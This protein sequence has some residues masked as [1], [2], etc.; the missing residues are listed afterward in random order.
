MLHAIVSVERL[1]QICPVL[2]AG[3]SSCAIGGVASVFAEPCLDSRIFPA[4]ACDSYGRLPRLLSN[5]IEGT[6][7]AIEFG[8]LSAERLPTLDDDVNLRALQVLAAERLG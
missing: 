7:V 4:A 6:S 5:F 8:F 1:F 3:A 2:T